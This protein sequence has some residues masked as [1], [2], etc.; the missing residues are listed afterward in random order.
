MT[1]RP[2]LKEMLKT[3]V[4]SVLVTGL[5]LIQSCMTIIGNRKLAMKS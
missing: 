2:A 4:I 5:S 3:N 1:N